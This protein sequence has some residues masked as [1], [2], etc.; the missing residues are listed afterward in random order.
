MSLHN[1]PGFANP[2]RIVVADDHPTILRLVKQLIEQEPHM[3]VVG[4]ASDG[5]TAVALVQELWPDV[6]VLNVVMPHMTGFEAARRIREK[7]PDTGIVILSTHKDEQ[8]LQL[9]RECGATAFV[10]KDEAVEELVKAIEAAGRGE[11]LLAPLA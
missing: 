9:A 1:A 2:L 7:V 11:R 6:V 8:F 5:A 4:S 3:K 10:S